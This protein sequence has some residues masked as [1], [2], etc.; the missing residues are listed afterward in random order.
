MAEA[1]RFVLGLDGGGSKT[2]ALVC[3]DT[4]H[5]VAFARDGGSEIYGA[6]D[7]AIATISDVARTAL[8]EA[9]LTGQDIGSAIFSL[10]GVDWPEDAVFVRAQLAPLFVCDVVVR[11]DALGALDGAIPAGPA[12]VVACGT[13]CATASRN[14]AGQTWFSGFWQHP[15]GSYELG[16]KALQAVC[17]AHQGMAEST[18]LEALALDALNLPDVE[19]LLHAVT[20][21]S[22]EGRV[23]LTRLTPLLLDAADGGDAVSRAIVQEHGAGLGRIAAVAAQKVG[24]SGGA[25]KIALSG[26][27]LRH[28]S[29]LLPDAV[30]DSVRHSEPLI[31]P[32]SPFGEPV[33]G[34]LI[35]GLRVLGVP[36]TPAVLA[37]LQRSIP[38]ASEFDTV[39]Q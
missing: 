4:G 8:T 37:T 23:S 20:Q 24:L 36:I 34:S 1:R 5:V 32:V 6:G 16:L 26:G 17:L 7:A 38:A 10:A 15:L 13:G 19:A 28:Q 22:P 29:T 21:R 14:Q 2:V 11:N 27:V 9:G 31:E 3:D 30:L 25:M 39:A 33:L 18:I 35:G 12:I